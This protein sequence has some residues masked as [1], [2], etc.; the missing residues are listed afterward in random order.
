MFHRNALWSIFAVRVS[1]NVFRREISR[2]L[3]FGI[4]DSESTRKWRTRYRVSSEGIGTPP[5][6]Y[7]NV[8][9]S[10]CQT[11]FYSYAVHSFKSSGGCLF[12]LLCPRWGGTRVQSKK[13]EDWGKGVEA[14][15][16]NAALVVLPSCLQLCS[17]GVT[18]TCCVYISALE[19]QMDPVLYQTF[20]IQS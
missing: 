11:F 16:G 12:C 3:D 7:P 10:Q 17:P 15:N 5:G 8:Y 14:A 4:V 1:I 2:W 9:M 18:G 20:Q 13:E 6:H 19:L